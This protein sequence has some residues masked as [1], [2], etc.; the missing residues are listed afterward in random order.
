MS[1]KNGTKTTVLGWGRNCNRPRRR[2]SQLF[3]VGIIPSGGSIRMFSSCVVECVCV[4]VCGGK[5]S[6]QG[7]GLSCLVRCSTTTHT[8]TPSQTDS[9]QSSLERRISCATGDKISSSGCLVEFGFSWS[10]ELGQ[11]TFRFATSA[12]AKE[13]R[14]WTA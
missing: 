3:D 5:S 14:S 2:S 4:C 1:A 8:D 10:S 6:Q 12:C 7:G 9:R 13:R 11:R